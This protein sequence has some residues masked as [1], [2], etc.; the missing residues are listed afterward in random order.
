M[1]H[2]YH[3]L[4]VAWIVFASVIAVA[5][6]AVAC[7]VAWGLIKRSTL[8]IQKTTND[9]LQTSVATLEKEV[10]DLK[11]KVLELTVLRDTWFSQRVVSD[12]ARERDA[13]VMATGKIEI[14][15]LE[16]ALAV[17]FEELSKLASPTAHEIA[18]MRGDLRQFRY[19]EDDKLTAW[20]HLQESTIPPA[21]SDLVVHD[22][23][24]P[25]RRTIRKQQQ[26]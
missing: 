13:R 10:E 9:T 26:D 16:D 6:T 15:M 24:R 5:L 2:A 25:R 22:T 19:T 11:D 21:K 3:L 8:E 18:K 4:D 1:A 20:Q 14:V 23:G 7:I 17:A 12:I